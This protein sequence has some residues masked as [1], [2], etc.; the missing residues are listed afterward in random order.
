MMD[1]F[2]S[3]GDAKKLRVERTTDDEN[4]GSSRDECA[5]K[6]QVQASASASCKCECKVQVVGWGAGEREGG[7]REG[8]RGSTSGW[9]NPKGATGDRRCDEGLLATV[10]MPG[11]F[12]AVSTLV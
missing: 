10:V 11:K 3:R 4:E 2:W 8:R 12:S 6:V 9:G 5:S 1:L 7:R